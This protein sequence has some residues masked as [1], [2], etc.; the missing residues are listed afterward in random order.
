MSEYIVGTL[1]FANVHHVHSI[2]FCVGIYIY[3]YIYLRKVSA[4]IVGRTY[5]LSFTVLAYIVGTQLFARSLFIFY[6]VGI[7]LFA[8]VHHA[9]SSLSFTMSAYIVGT[10]F[11]ANGRHASRMCQYIWSAQ[12]FLQMSTKLLALSPIPVLANT[13]CDF[14]LQ[15]LR[16][17]K[18]NNPCSYLP[19]YSQHNTFFKCPPRFW[20][21]L[22]Y[23]YWPIR[24]VIFPYN[25]FVTT[26]VT[27]HV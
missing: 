11:F 24:I 21:H 3:I 25:L 26:N 18:C 5:S 10:Q 2:F 22:L 20:H 23:P 14:S 6:C 4:Y 7:Q 16:H 17:H 19:L 13:D 15:S 27:I 1:L 9:H 8:N 12:Y